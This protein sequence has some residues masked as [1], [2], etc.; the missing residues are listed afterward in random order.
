MRALRTEKG[1][2]V[3]IIFDVEK[4]VREDTLS[5]RRF[6]LLLPVLEGLNIIER[7]VRNIFCCYL[8]RGDILSF[9]TILETRLA[10][11]HEP[12]NEIS[13]PFFVHSWPQV[14]SVSEK[15]VFP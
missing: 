6:D 7:R 5:Q 14:N 11:D 13:S 15:R 1:D 2:D 9:N 10:V 3:E 12:G 8:K 4:F